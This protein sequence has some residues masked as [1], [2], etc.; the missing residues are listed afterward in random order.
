MSCEGSQSAQE[1][2]P[3]WISSI[4]K[5]QWGMR[6]HRMA[7]PERARQDL[8][9]PA[10]AKRPGKRVEKSRIEEVFDYVGLPL[11]WLASSSRNP[12][13]YILPQP[14]TAVHVLASLDNLFATSNP[15]VGVLVLA[16]SEDVGFGGM[17]QSATGAATH[18]TVARYPSYGQIFA[19]SL[20]GPKLVISTE[21]IIG[22][23]IAPPWRR[24]SSAEQREQLVCVPHCWTTQKTTTA[25]P[26]MFASGGRRLHPEIFAQCVLTSSL[27]FETS[28]EPA[29]HASMMRTLLTPPTQITAL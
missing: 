12:V 20:L 24:S 10:A 4:P 13:Q 19:A 17:P 11:G 7:M 29:M 8:S 27:G 5:A 3:T 23:R 26:T 2:G 16:S 18:A 25:G 1:P 28:Q 6:Q 22:H 21:A 15:C 9:R 14:E